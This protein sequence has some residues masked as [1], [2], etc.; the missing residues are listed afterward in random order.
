VQLQ[1]AQDLHMSAQDDLDRLR[2]EVCSLE[3]RQASPIQSAT[4]L[5]AQSDPPEKCQQS[6]CQMD[7]AER[8]S[9]TLNASSALPRAPLAGFAYSHKAVAPSP[10]L[11]FNTKWRQKGTWGAMGLGSDD[12]A[13][14]P[15]HLSVAR[16]YSTG[17]TWG[18]RSLPTLPPLQ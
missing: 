5:S 7:C 10:S 12:V 17:T 15:Q 8:S 2:K 16:L 14:F 4:M 3:Q 11:P 18:S 9:S 1:L 13:A 6:A